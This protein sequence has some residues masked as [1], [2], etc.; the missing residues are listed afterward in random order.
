[1]TLQKLKNNFN[2]TRFAV[3]CTPKI[4]VYFGGDELVAP[5][6]TIFLRHDI[7]SLQYTHTHRHTHT[8]LFACRND[9]VLYQCRSIIGR[10]YM[11]THRHTHT[12]GCL[13]AVIILSFTNADR[14]LDANTC[15]LTDTHTPGCLRAVIILSFTNADRILD[16]YT[17]IHTDTHTWLFACRE[18]LEPFTSANQLL[19][20]YTR[21]LTD[22]QTQMHT[23]LA[24][25][26]P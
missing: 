6:R 4:F 11:H 3:I 22:T 2:N 18:F 12:P 5:P 16:A 8:W 20:A 26:V 21:I 1:M 15:I 19:D 10:V 24:I 14:L 23:H 7:L 13:R 25:C 17:C 9:I